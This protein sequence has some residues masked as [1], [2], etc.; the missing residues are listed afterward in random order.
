MAKI[1]EKKRRNNRVV[2]NIEFKLKELKDCIK[3][4][5]PKKYNWMM[6]K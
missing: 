6:F 5:R 4:Y 2:R 1:E 3:I